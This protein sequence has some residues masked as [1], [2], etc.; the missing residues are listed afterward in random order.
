MKVCSIVAGAFLAEK[1]A[2][3]DSRG[4]AAF[5]PGAIL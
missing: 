2:A 1:G 4:S 5:V 3:E